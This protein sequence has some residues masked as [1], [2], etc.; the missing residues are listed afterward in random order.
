M[1]QIIIT[2]EAIEAIDI[3]YVIST[4]IGELKRGNP[5]DWRSIV[6]VEGISNAQI[7]DILKPILL[8]VDAP[9]DIFTRVPLDKIHELAGGNEVEDIRYLDIEMN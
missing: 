5:A 3:K 1:D 7:A 6:F 8:S 9:F 4:V 2:P